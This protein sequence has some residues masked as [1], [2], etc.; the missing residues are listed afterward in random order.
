VQAMMGNL[1]LNRLV[2]TARDA[3]LAVR[4]RMP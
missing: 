2:R 1:S 4:G 3:D